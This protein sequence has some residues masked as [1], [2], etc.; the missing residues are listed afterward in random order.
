M[1]RIELYVIQRICGLNSELLRECRNNTNS[2]HTNNIISEGM[3]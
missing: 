3:L 2:E 1:Q